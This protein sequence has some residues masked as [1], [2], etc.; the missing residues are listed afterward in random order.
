MERY[1]AKIKKIEWLDRENP[2]A[3]ILFEI[4]EKEFW[5]FCHPC[6]FN[7]GEILNV[8]LSF[9]E[10]DIPESSF[11]NENKEQVRRIDQVGTNRCSYVC[12]GQLK[13][14]HPVLID[15][16]II[17]LSLGDWISDEKAIGCY[18]YFIISRL[19]ISK[20]I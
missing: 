13:T 18:V 1:I 15:C 9:I 12:Y 7:E 6:N 19:D 4:K 5:A 20:I 17:T 3:E 11:W 14:I 10:E 2:E 16:G 8:S